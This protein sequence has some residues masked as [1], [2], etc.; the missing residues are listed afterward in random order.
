M[1]FHAIPMLGLHYDNLSRYL[2][3][4]DAVLGYGN[5]GVDIFLFLSGIPVF[6][7]GT[8]FGKYVYEGRRLPAWIYAAAAL[9][10]AA[11]ICVMYA[12]LDQGN[13][14]RYLLGVMGVSIAFLA[15]RESFASEPLFY[16]CIS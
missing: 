12:G 8:A 13:P 9:V 4:V 16:Y 7:V 14:G 2:I 10:I 3:P 5:I 15:P 11:G 6:I 1:F